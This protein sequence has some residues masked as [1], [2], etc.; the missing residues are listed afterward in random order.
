MI[1]EREETNE[2]S[3]L[4]V[5]AYCLERV[6]KTQFREEMNLGVQEPRYL[7]FHEQSIR[8]ASQREL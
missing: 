5:W 6:F 4:I 8:Q 7:E 3:A 1:S 2:E